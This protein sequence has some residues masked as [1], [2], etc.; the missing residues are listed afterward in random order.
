MKAKVEGHSDLYKDTET[1]VITNSNNSEREKYR[2][3]KMNAKRA[4]DSEYE[5]KEIKEELSELS[6]LKEEVSELKD[7]LQKVLGKLS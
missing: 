7:L 4:L 2:I 1:G 3:T 5:I 6:E